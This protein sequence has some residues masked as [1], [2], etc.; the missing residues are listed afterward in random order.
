MKWLW[1][2][3]AWAHLCMGTP[4]MGTCR[5]AHVHAGL[6]VDSDDG[7]LRENI[8]SCCGKNKGQFT[9]LPPSAPSLD[10]RP[11]GRRRNTV[12]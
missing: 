5:H 11:P 4:C 1:L 10:L 7:V 12:D 9:A 2:W 3:A 8:P 6:F